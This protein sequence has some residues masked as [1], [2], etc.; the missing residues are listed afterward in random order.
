MFIILKFIIIKGFILI[1][2]SEFKIKFNIFFFV[3][4]IFSFILFLV[5]LNLRFFSFDDIF[6]NIFL[7]LNFNRVVG[8]K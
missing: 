3:L 6:I 8:E 1:H 7:C 2:L 4:S 5:R